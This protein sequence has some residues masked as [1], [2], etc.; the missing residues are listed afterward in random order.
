[1]PLN[2]TPHNSV[3]ADG[4]TLPLITGNRFTSSPLGHTA[5]AFL[6]QSI[7][8]NQFRRNVY[9]AHH[10]RVYI[11][12][13]AYGSCDREGRVYKPFRVPLSTLYV[14]ILGDDSEGDLLLGVF[15]LPVPELGENDQPQHFSVTL[16]G[17]Q[18]VTI[19]IALGDGAGRGVPEY[20]IQL[21][22]AEAAKVDTLNAKNPAVEAIP[23]LP[24][25]KTVAL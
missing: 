24:G 25:P 6:K 21:S 23:A 3:P 9:R 4:S 2:D 17:G 18:A 16:E 13:E 5:L 10:L 8:R 12:G 11:D 7:E 19:E 1:M 20:V 22:Y 14:E 15:L